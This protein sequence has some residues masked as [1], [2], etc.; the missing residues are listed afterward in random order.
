MRRGWLRDYEKSYTTCAFFRP[1]L[2]PSLTHNSFIESLQYFPAYFLILQVIKAYIVLA[3][4][5]RLCQMSFT[6]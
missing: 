5:T 2:Q 3:Q 1:L 4:L 6:C